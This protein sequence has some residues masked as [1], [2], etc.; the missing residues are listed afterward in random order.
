MRDKKEGFK[1]A[2]GKQQVQGWAKEL[3]GDAYRRLLS[4]VPMR[5]EYDPH[6]CRRLDQKQQVTNRETLCMFMSAK[7]FLPRNTIGF[8]SSTGRALYCKKKRIV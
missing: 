8:T 3:S 6:S 1:G 7:A 2:C 4:K 5:L